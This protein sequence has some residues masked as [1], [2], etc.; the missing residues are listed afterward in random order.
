MLLLP[1]PLFSLLTRRRL[2]EQRILGIVTA[3]LGVMGMFFDHA[4]IFF[5][6]ANHLF[7]YFY[8]CLTSMC[9][10]MVMIDLFANHLVKAG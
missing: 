9:N 3:I 1:V 4:L 2:S 6:F 7:I 10:R 8:S 5:G